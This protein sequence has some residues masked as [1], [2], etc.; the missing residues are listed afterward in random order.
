LSVKR[1]AEIRETIDEAKYDEFREQQILHSYGAWQVVT[2]LA[3]SVGSKRRSTFRQYAES[4]NLFDKQSA[5]TKDEIK[6]RIHA[7]KEHALAIA[8]RVQEKGK[9]KGWVKKDFRE[10]PVQ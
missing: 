10:I 1:F 8:K 9:K 7:E 4:L 6:K 3:A 5:E 2:V